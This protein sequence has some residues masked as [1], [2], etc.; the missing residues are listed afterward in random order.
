LYVASARLYPSR[1]PELEYPPGVHLRRISQQGS[2]KWKSARAFVSEVLAR[3]YVGLLEVQEEFFEVYYGPLLLG[4]LDAAGSE[5]VFA[6]D[7]GPDKRARRAAPAA[8]GG[9][10]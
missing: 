1:L 8:A 3:A 2:V 4:W 5:P 10:R 7:R 9:R 6:A